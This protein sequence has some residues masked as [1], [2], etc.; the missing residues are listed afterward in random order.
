MSRQARQ[1]L[2]EILKDFF[3]FMETFV[4]ESEEELEIQ[5]YGH[6]AELYAG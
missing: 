3:F 6:A 1:E 5:E 4:E 2:T